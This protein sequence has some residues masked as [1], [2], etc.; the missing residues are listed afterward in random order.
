MADQQQPTLMG[1]APEMRD[2]IIK[3]LLIPADSLTINASGTGFTSVSTLMA[4]TLGRGE[5]RSPQHSLHGTLRRAASWP[6]V[7]VSRFGEEAS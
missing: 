4:S 5:T 6:S 3:H 2:A 7:A 1:I